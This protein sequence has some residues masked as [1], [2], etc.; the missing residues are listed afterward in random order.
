MLR[1]KYRDLAHD[2]SAGQHQTLPTTATYL[3]SGGKGVAFDRPVVPLGSALLCELSQRTDLDE[4][5][6]GAVG[7]FQGYRGTFLPHTAE[8]LWEPEPWFSFP[9]SAETY[10]TAY[11]ERLMRSPR[12]LNCLVGLGQLAQQMSEREPMD[13]WQLTL[14]PT[15]LGFSPD[16]AGLI[17]RL[18]AQATQSVR[19]HAREYGLTTEEAWLELD[20]ATRVDGDI[21]M[22]GLRLVD[23]RLCADHETG[24]G[25]LPE[26]L[27]RFHDLRPIL[28]RR[29][30]NPMRKLTAEEQ[31]AMVELLDTHHDHARA[32]QQLRRMMLREISDGNLITALRNPD[33]PLIASR[34]AKRQAWSMA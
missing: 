29:C 7:R 4:H 18:T 33:R 14:P 9:V 20:T 17:D 34:I 28:G 24:T 13:Y 10:A 22:T 3:P 2:L 30:T 15:L 6:D 5:I 23:A 21:E 8:T 25:H 1:N 26:A 11:D 16:E 32:T 19:T 31:S 27:S 12:F